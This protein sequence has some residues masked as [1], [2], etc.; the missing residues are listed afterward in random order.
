[1]NG[2]RDR[3][4]SGAVPITDLVARFGGNL[5]ECS[6]A[7]GIAR[8]TLRDRLRAEAARRSPR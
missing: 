5:S 2:G 1:M 7:T 4:A 8:T 6:R 3:R